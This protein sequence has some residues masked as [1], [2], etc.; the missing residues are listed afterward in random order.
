MHLF[1]LSWDEE[2]GQDVPHGGS[3]LASNPDGI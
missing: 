2:S 1:Y 3:S